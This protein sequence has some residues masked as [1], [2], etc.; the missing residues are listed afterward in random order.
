M[1]GVTDT[2]ELLLR[3][4]FDYDRCED[5]AKWE[6][7]KILTE[8]VKY[9]SVTWIS[10]R[11]GKSVSY[12]RMMVQIYETFPDEGDR[13]RELSFYHYRV[14]AAAKVGNPK[15]WIEI[16][17]RE[18]LST[19]GLWERMRGPRDPAPSFKQIIEALEK[20]NERLKAENNRLKSIIKVI[21]QKIN[22][23]A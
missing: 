9:C 14:A 6:K 17:A 1:S 16:A 4:Y 7:A 3:N 23:V 18:K 15:E 11:I 13:K 8:L 5:D 21:R 19:R 20:E 10:L 12:I 2:V 22:L